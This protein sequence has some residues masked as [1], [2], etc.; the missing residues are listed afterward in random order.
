[1]CGAVCSGFFAA[2]HGFPKAESL[3]RQLFKSLARGSPQ[4]K[5]M[6]SLQTYEF[7]QPKFMQQ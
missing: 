5:P 6:I 1:L 3:L 4:E 7:K 2:L